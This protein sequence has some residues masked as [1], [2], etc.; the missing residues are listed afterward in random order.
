MVLEPSLE[1]H[2]YKM[3]EE[4]DE[5]VFKCVFK[6]FTNCTKLPNQTVYT[7]CLIVTTDNV[8]MTDLAFMTCKIVK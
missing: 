7:W 1:R 3:T 4:Y 5:G 2:G 6:S 8:F